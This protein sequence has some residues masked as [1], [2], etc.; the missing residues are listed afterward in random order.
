MLVYGLI[1]T[2]GSVKFSTMIFRED[3][4]FQ[5]ETKKYAVNPDH[6]FTAVDLEFD[7]YF[8]VLATNWDEEGATVYE[9]YSKA[10]IEKYINLKFRQSIFAGSWWSEKID[11]VDC[12]DENLTS[13][14][15]ALY[16]GSTLLQTKKIMS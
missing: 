10:E 8:S 2:Y 14:E 15:G 6:N 11:L 13:F 5:T 1:I 7:V 9:Y 16:Q 12:S 3:T 4:N